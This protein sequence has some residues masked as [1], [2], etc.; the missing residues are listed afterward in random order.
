[1][2]YFTESFL[3]AIDTLPTHFLISVVG[4]KVRSSQLLS[5]HAIL[6]L[7]DELRTYYLMVSL[8]TLLIKLIS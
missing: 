5:I 8:F 1:M 4:V 7:K 6:N 2:S 3:L